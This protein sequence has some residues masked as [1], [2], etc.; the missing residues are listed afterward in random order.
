VLKNRFLFYCFYVVLGITAISCTKDPD[1]IGLDLL[2]P[3]DRL[4][5]DFIDTSTIIAYTIREDS[6]RTD[7]LTLNL[8]GSYTDP[9]F[10]TTTASFYTQYHLSKNNV[11]FET[12]AVADSMV[13]S[14][15]YKGFYGDST[16]S[17]TIRV[18]EMADTIS[19]DSTY[20]S[21]HVIPF[22]PELI[23]EAT[24]VPNF[25]EADSVDGDYNSPHM[26]VML[27]QAFM[28]R[29][30]S[31][32]SSTLANNENFKKVFKGLYITAEQ[33]NTPGTG[34]ILY[35]NLL[36]AVSRLKLYYHY[37]SDSTIAS[38]IVFPIGSTSARYNF[39]E[40]NDYDD[41]DPLLIQQLNGDTTLGSQHLYMQA[42]AGLKVKVRIPYLKALAANKR[43]AINEALLVFNVED[44]TGTYTIPAQIAIR[45]ITGEGALEVLPDETMGT[46][47]VD[48][49]D[50]TDHEYRF[51]ITR[52][53]QNRLLNPDEPD[54]GLI[55][56]AAGSS[57]TGNRVILKGTG[58]NEGKVRLLI[59]YTIVD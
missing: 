31:A 5:I 7:E 36:D 12:N 55:L 8:L 33:S 11:K 38:S 1:L 19:Y 46:S 18:Y 49:K 4:N 56:F 24:F 41:A 28:D 17:K 50:R 13:L 51:R 45:K 54:Y 47:F 30:I 21:N 59:Y 52:Y 53:V 22:A 15:A 29:I 37:V 23:G 26:R 44:T 20:Y 34:S 32:D 57:L 58:T 35:L 10:G 16:A 27:S 2:P 40:H 6:L 42:M 9:V 3:G 25:K 14:I 48:G 39:Y 43:I